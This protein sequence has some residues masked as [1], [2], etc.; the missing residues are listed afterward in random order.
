MR[1]PIAAA[2]A[3]LSGLLVTTGCSS[4]VTG[5]T[6]TAAPQSSTSTSVPGTKVPPYGGAPKVANPLSA[7]V[8]S[9]SPC[10]ALTP[11]QLKVNLGKVVAGEPDRLEGVG[12]KCTWINPDTSGQIAVYFSTEDHQG[13]SGVYANTQP[14][15]KTWKV[16]PPIQGLP[17]VAYSD[18]AGP[19]PDFCEVTVGVM[20]TATVD[21]GIFLSNR[22]LGKVDACSIVPDTAN[23]VITTLKQKA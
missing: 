2:V 22:N 12:Q 4:E 23:D 3:L 18:K 19:T 20:D 6:P 10:D 7:T 14:K 11:E 13:L 15:M 1:R 5:G 16:L 8:V 21:I 9:G 17:A